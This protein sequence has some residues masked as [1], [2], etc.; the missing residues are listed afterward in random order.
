MTTAYKPPCI[1][2]GGEG[3]A[4]SCSA[5]RFVVT[6][7][8]TYIGSVD[9]DAA[10]RQLEI[11][12]DEAR[13]ELNFIKSEYEKANASDLTRDALA[14]QNAALKAELEEANAEVVNH[15]DDR[16][17]LRAEVSRLKRKIEDAPCLAARD[18]EMTY[19]C[20]TDNLCRVCRWRSESLED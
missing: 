4:T 17:R 5:P 3:C 2:C 15:K 16:L 18:G 9:F 10:L 12:R 13:A 14:L 19:E 7:G 20:R 6:T 1:V 11:E 8:G